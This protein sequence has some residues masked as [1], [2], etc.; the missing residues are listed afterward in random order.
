MDYRHELKFP[1]SD[2]ELE[3][4]RYRLAPLMKQDIHQ[5][6]GRYTV[7]SLYFDDLNDSCM[8]ENEAGIGN[9]HKFRIRMYNHDDTVI[10]LEKKE[11]YREMA[12]KES[13]L[14]SKADCLSYINGTMGKL[15]KDSVK[16]EKELY[17]EIKVKGM[18]PVSIV[19]YERTA[20]VEPRG[21]VRITFDQNISG[22]SIMNRFF[23]ERLALVPLLPAGI[24]I[25]EVKYDELLPQYIYETLNMGTL[26]RSSFSKY[27]YSRR[28]FTF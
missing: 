8:R 20:F 3:L 7:R 23:D 22:S 28:K 16:I 11:K 6:H 12:R 19:E 2:M 13:V 1:V 17:A 27:Y 15:C 21:N 14:I 4:I 10:K 24:H 26:Q 25:L 5:N 18:H 9:R